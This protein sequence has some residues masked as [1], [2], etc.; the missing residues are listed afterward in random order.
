MRLPRE[1]QRKRMPSASLTDLSLPQVCRPTVAID[2][3]EGK[4]LANHRLRVSLA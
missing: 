3:P 4:A 2:K 1:D